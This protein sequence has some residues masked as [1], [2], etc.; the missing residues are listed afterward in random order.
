MMLV[1][2]VLQRRTFYFAPLVP[3]HHAFVIFSDRTDFCFLKHP[4]YASFY[5]NDEP[6]PRMEF[7]IGKQSGDENRLQLRAIREMIPKGVF[8]A[9]ITLETMKPGEHL[10]HIRVELE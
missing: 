1:N 3:A 5:F 6:V 8:A 9:K 7:F 2:P 4:V 10:A